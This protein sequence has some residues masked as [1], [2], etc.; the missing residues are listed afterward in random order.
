MGGD[1]A[2]ETA[3]KSFLLGVRAKLQLW[4]PARYLGLGSAGLARGG[5]LVA[6]AFRDLNGDGLKEPGEPPI[7]GVGFRGGAGEVSTN[8]RGLA[9]VTGLGDGRPAQVSMAATLPDP[10]MFPSRPGVEVVP[11]PGRTHRALFPVVAVS[12][13][14]GHAYFQGIDET[15]SVKR[16]TATG[17]CQRR[18]H[19]FGS[20]GV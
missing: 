20:N 19:G 12:E 5:S 10:Y 11:R 3:T 14:E 17:R 2:Y 9:L 6:L 1:V 8:S 4:K 13:V 7:E 15:P 18:R 16:P